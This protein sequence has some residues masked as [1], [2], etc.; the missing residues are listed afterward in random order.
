MAE[1]ASRSVI[2]G[3]IRQTINELHKLFAFFVRIPFQTYGLK[4]MRDRAMGKP[5]M[6][7]RQAE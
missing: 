1:R 3:N 7:R 4:P 5:R 6:V 2:C